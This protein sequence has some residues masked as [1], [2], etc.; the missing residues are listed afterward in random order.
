MNL[1]TIQIEVP[2]ETV[3]LLRQNAAAH[4]LSL[5]EYLRTI[6]ENDSPPQMMT[7]DEILAPFSAEVEA[8]GITDGELDHLIRAARMEVFKAKQRPEHQ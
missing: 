3:E 4:N 5:A 8:S 7:F 2:H 6:A 1:Q